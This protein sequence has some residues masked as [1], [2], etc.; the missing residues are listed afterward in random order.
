MFATVTRVRGIPE[1]KLNFVEI[2]EKNDEF[3]VFKQKF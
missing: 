3:G 2:K 1:K